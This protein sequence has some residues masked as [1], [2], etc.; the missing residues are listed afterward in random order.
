LPAKLRH[1]FGRDPAIAALCSTLKARRFVS[2]VG[3]GGVGKTSVAVAVAHALM[4]D[5]GSAICFVDSADVSDATLVASTIAA[6][7]GCPD[8]GHAATPAVLALLADR[9][10]LVILDGCEHVIATVAT[11]AEAVYRSAPYVHLLTTSRE[12]LRVD[13]EN[14]H[15]LASLDCPRAEPDLTAVRALAFPAVQLFMDRAAASGYSFELSDADALSVAQI[16]RGLDGTALAIELAATRVG[17]LGIQ[18]AAELLDHPVKLL[19]TG[20]RESLPRHQSLKAMLDWSYESLP[21]YEQNVLCALS[22]FVS[23][24][25]LSAARAVADEAGDDVSRVVAAVMSLVEKSLVTIASESGPSRYRLLNVTRAYAFTRLLGS[26]AEAITRERHALYHAHYGETEKLEGASL[27]DSDGAAYR[28]YIDNA[29][30]ALAYCFSNSATVSLGVK[31]AVAAVPLFLARSLLSECRH[32]SSL[33]LD[34]LGAGE[35][36]SRVELVLQAAFAFSAMYTH[37]V[38]DDVSRALERGL[39]VAEALGDATHQ[40][41]L[42]AGQNMLLTRSGDFTVALALAERY[43][44]AADKLEI[45]SGAVVSHWLLG[46]SHHLSGNQAA[47]RRHYQLG[48]QQLAVAGP[49]PANCFGYDHRVHALAGYAR[50]LWLSGLPE[51]ALRLAHQ[52]IG[53]AL[54]SEHA[55]TLCHCLLQVIP[56]F[57]WCGSFDTAETLLERL[58][59][60]AIKHGLA[61]Y[62]AGGLALQGELLV[63]R[64]EA[65]SGVKVLRGALTSLAEESQHTLWMFF[66]R[67]LAEGLLLCSKAEEA[68]AVIT[69]AVKWAEAHGKTYAHPELLRAKAQILLALSGPDRRA[70][71]EC[72]VSSLDIAR[73]QSAL[74]WALRSAISLAR[75]LSEHGRGDKAVAILGNVY[76]C[77]E[78]GFATVDL[79]TAR[80]LLHELSVSAGATSTGAHP[81]RHH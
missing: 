38:E 42:L 23:S 35:R 50:A 53:E 68:L 59:A 16:C 54:S 21:R 32:W 49:V 22:V 71:E 24:F 47:A 37:S 78:E 30:V 15:L 56:L 17:A 11:F 57:V 52:A 27:R 6:A 67:A 29:R 81:A 3:P 41:S 25:T 63:L 36:G 45:Q 7:L 48:F 44:V 1:L 20:R 4:D 40:F 70:V 46:S 55:A 64:G 65:A 79:C 62:R 58:I 10:L 34:H 43:A 80:Q 5:F 76:Q 18:G 66:S 69:D 12:A 28:A 75:L 14:V 26:D 33:A 13:G 61:P 73:R 2:I 51:Q 74:G 31:L 77:F 72:L 19:W 60:Q 39:A 8:R 9:R